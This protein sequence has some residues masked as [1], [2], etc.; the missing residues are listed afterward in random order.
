MAKIIG[1]CSGSAG[2]KYDLWLEVKQNS[3]S[4][5]ANTSNVTVA[6]KLKR[7]DG[8]ASSAYNLNEDE[9]SV[10]LKVGDSTKVN[11]TLKIDTRNNVTVTLATWTGD[12][13]HNDDGTLSL[14]LSGSFTMSGTKLSSGTV[15]GSFKCSTIA[16]TSTF[17]V[18]KTSVNPE[19]TITLTISSASKKLSHKVICSIGDYK[20][21]KEIS[22]GVSS[23]TITIPI[24]WANALPKTKKGTIAITLK[25]YSGNKAVGTSKK[26][27]SLKIPETDDFLPTF[28][29]QVTSNKSSNIP[30]VWS[31]TIKNNS[32]ITV[33]INSA[34]S[35]YGAEIVSGS[36]TFDGITKKGM[37]ADFPLLNAGTL[38]VV[39]KVTDSRGFIK[40]E[41]ALVE[42]D[43]YAPPVIVC[44]SIV[45]CDSS[46]NPSSSGN[47]A[48]VDF[49]EVYSSV[50]G[51][52]YATVKVKHRKNNVAEYS[53]YVTLST[54]PAI[55][56][57]DFEKASSYEFLLTITDALGYTFETVRTLSSAG[58]AFNV[59]KGGAGAAFGC[60]AENDN[61]LT[62]GYDLNVKGVIKSNDL[63]PYATFNSNFTKNSLVLKNYN[64]LGFTL[65]KA[66]F[67]VVT[68]VSTNTAVNV[69]TVG[70]TPPSI[71]TPLSVSTGNYEIDKNLRAYIDTTGQVNI[72]SAVSISAGTTIYINGIY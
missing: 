28:S 55:V 48:L 70:N 68:A 24:E 18:D 57:G 13:A 46:G 17:T 34:Y 23:V 33:K 38:D 6:L 2:Y 50:R 67:K 3:Q 65:V 37:E 43:E 44:N 45:R 69:F 5:T 41:I 20:S 72:I 1:N 11:K 53:D 64:C 25:T 8:Y 54:S 56:S 30:G 60:Y 10:L 9:N 39:C 31:A 52:N 12:V 66:V 40:E 29:V 61:E 27:I 36:I 21:T 59:K 4:I 16:R 47:C 15:S 26:N 22:A 49:T 63:T 71:Q 58:V 35:Q 19:D 14:S 62:V 32:T 7:N 51:L 42:V